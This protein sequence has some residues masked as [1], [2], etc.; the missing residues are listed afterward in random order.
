RRLCRVHDAPVTVELDLSHGGQLRDEH[1]SRERT[2]GDLQR[3][4]RNLRL[5]E[6]V[7]YASGDRERRDLIRAV[8]AERAELVGGVVVEHERGVAED[9]WDD[10]RGGFGGEK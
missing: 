1:T 4:R 8:V 3:N 10:R 9:R 6:V 7:R 2:S 5:G